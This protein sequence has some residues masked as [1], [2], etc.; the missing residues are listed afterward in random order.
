MLGLLARESG[1]V[2][3]SRRSKELY[4]LE[5]RLG[6]QFDTDLREERSSCPLKLL[7]ERISMPR[8]VGDI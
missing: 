1:Q 8:K 2:T 6:A 4:K 5:L 3:R 7:G